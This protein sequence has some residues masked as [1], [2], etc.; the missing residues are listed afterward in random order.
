[1]MTYEELLELARLCA[2]NSQIATDREVAHL[3]WQ[4]AKEYQAKAA[5]SPRRAIDHRQP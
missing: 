1:M 5:K 3:L 4:M 2:Y